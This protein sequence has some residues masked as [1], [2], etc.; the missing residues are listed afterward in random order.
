MNRKLKDLKEQFII[1]PNK[2]MLTVRVKRLVDRGIVVLE[3]KGE[4]HS[5][6][7][8]KYSQNRDWWKKEAIQ[9]YKELKRQ[10]L[11]EKIK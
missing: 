5:V 10:D 4:F 1:K 6:I 9:I 7:F 11:K 3:T 8:P 2:K